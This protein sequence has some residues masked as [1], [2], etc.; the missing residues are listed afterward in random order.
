MIKLEIILVMAM[1][2]LRDCIGRILQMQFLSYL[3]LKNK[4][5]KL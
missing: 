1:I 3:L 5:E 4:D 2:F